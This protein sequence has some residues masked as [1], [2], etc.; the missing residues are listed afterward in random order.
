M[1]HP[2]GGFPA[3]LLRDG[4]VLIGDIKD[5]GAAV[6]SIG[7][8]L[9][10]PKSETWSSTGGVLTTPGYSENPA[11]ATLLSDGR[12]LVTSEDGA[13]VYDPASGTWSA[14]EKMITPRHDHTATLLPD[15]TVLVAGG[16]HHDGMVYSAELYDPATGSWT[17]IANTHSD[18][19]CRSGCPHLGSLA[20]LLPDGTLLFVRPAPDREFAE[21]YDPSTGAWTATSA[22]TGPGGGYSSISRLGDGR[23]LVAGGQGG[24]DAA[25]TAEVFDPATGSWTKADDMVY[26]SAESLLFNRQA[27]ATL[28]RDGT[29]L[30][31]GTSRGDATSW[32]ELYVPAG[33]SPPAAVVALPTP[34]PTPVP[35]PAPTPVPTP[36][37]TPFPPA[38]GPVPAGARTW[39]AKVVNKS[40]DPATIL[41]AEL[42]A[43][44]GV[45]RLCGSV[46]PNVVPAGVTRNVTFQLPPKRMD[47]CWIWINARPGSGGSL[48]QTSDFPMKGY[49][50]VPGQNGPHGDNDPPDRPPGGWVGS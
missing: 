5:P 22:M 17:A 35:T 50:Y 1:I 32:A 21:I 37:P 31:A 28:L 24:P 8:E 7:A 36:I 48:L 45:G 43:E 2:Y 13:R 38:D 34:A 47:D 11:T 26:D 6:W 27:P 15:G 40:A 46:T 25:G 12:V 29:V 10:D 41:L 14:T 9:Y 20:T 42:N 4:K 39:T 44:G 16:V 3:T 19:R 18:G 33:V 49:F 30:L 23:V